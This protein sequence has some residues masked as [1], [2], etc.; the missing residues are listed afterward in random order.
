MNSAQQARLAAI[1]PTLASASIALNTSAMY[2]GQ[3][4]GA[5]LGG[6]LIGAIG[7]GALPF[8]AAALLVA[9][10]VLSSRLHVGAGTLHHEQVREER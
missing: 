3:A 9:T 6:A 8:G 10:W 4:S 7:I 1:A 2:A 5:A